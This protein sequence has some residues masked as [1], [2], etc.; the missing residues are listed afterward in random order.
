[1]L[2][3]SVP[4]PQIMGQKSTAA[5]AAAAH[6]FEF[7]R[8]DY[9]ELI[10]NYNDEVLRI[11][12]SVKSL[13]MEWKRFWYS[14]ANNCTTVIKGSHE[15]SQIISKIE[16]TP[17]SIKLI[18]INHTFRSILSNFRLSNRFKQHWPFKLCFYFGTNYDLWFLYGSEW[19]TVCAQL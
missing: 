1:M 8:I 7:I 17:I 4:P 11:F 9:F 16:H 10:Y 3:A 18:K 6:M 13:K 12:V 2:C 19:Y 14:I 15:S 5:T